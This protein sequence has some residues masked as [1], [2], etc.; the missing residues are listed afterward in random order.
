MTAFVFPGQ[1][2]QKKGMGEGLF[3]EVPQY[4]AV[5]KEVDAILGYSM[6]RLCLEDPD[7]QLTQTQYT[8]PSLYVVNALHYYKAAGQGT[9]PDYVAGHSL[10]E[11]NALLAAGAF[12]FLTGLRLV[13]KR[14]E[15][16]SQA[17]NGG[18]GAVIGL[19]A[20]TVAKVLR[21]NGLTTLDV[22]NFNTPSQTVVSGPVEDVK[23][24][25][26]FFEKAGAQMYIPLQVSA[27]F[28]SRY[29]ASAAKAFAEFL[30]PLSFAA[31]RIP[32]VA[33]ATA[34]PYPT[35]NA[36][37]A[38]KSLLVDQITGSVQWTQTVRFLIRQGVTQFSE[39]GPGNVLTRMVQQIRQQDM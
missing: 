38:I 3:D 20:D 10:G 7:R 2:S 8:Q 21:D 39:M 14:G 6:R 28:H 1:G 18:M 23:R 25:G 32:V 35:V 31:P 15:L 36:S 26:P 33:N 13:Q 34:Q 17:K 4:A 11:Y 16:M 29:M 27:A 30:A 22:A 19:S 37:E 9:Q 12:D 24:A 5:E